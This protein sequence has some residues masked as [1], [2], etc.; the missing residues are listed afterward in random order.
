MEFCISDGNAETGVP[1]GTEEDM[2]LPTKAILGNGDNSLTWEGGVQWDGWGQAARVPREP[3]SR[4]GTRERRLQW[5][6]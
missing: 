3:D 1:E 6:A 2:L 5:R 4:N